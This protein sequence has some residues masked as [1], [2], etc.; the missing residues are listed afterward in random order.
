M[1]RVLGTLP[2]H[3]AMGRAMKPLNSEPSPPRKSGMPAISAPLVMSMWRA[4]K[5]Y[6]GSQVM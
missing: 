5:R 6:V 2:V 4:S 3:R 1:R